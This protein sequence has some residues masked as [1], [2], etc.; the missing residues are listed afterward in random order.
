[1]MQD[2]YA[3]HFFFKQIMKCNERKENEKHESMNL[4]STVMYIHCISWATGHSEI[5]R[6]GKNDYVII[7]VFSQ[8]VRWL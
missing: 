1:M 2:S 6:C 8:C 5:H 4:K 7:N 3:I